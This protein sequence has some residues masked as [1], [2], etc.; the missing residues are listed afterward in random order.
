MNKEKFYQ[1]LLKKLKG[2]DKNEA[3]AIIEY[4]DELIEEKIDNGYTEEEAI[5]SFG[6]VDDIIRSI[7]AEVVI[8][9]SNDKKTNSLRNFLIILG[10]CSSPIL[11]PI[12]IAFFIVFISLFICLISIFFAFS[13]AAIAV[14]VSSIYISISMMTSGTEIAIILLVIGGALLA[15]SILSVLSISIYRISKIILHFINNLFGKLIKNR[16]KKKE[17]EYV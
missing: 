10:V 14:F 8:K 5:K 17:I 16:I 2:F 1:E 11:I 4:F 12:G 6:N 3:K 15:T 9:R 13:S 7:K